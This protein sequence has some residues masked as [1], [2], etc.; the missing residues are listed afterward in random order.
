MIDEKCV[1]CNGPMEHKYN[2]MKEWNVKGFL[3]GKCY[4]KKIFEHYPGKHER[5][6]QDGH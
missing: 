5:V 3:C 1:L 6:N 4:S 2:P